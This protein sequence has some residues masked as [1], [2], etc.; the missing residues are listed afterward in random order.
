MLRSL[1]VAACLDASMSPGESLAHLAVLPALEVELDEVARSRESHA[2]LP[3][4]CS[5]GRRPAQ[6]KKSLMHF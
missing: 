6:F 4:S 3:Q 2:H 1:C 5:P